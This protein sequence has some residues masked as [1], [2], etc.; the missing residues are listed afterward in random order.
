MSGLP[1]SEVVEK[2]K[3]I[4]G[5]LFDCQSDAETHSKICLAKE[6]MLELWKKSD[7]GWI[8]NYE[9]DAVK[10]IVANWQAFLEILQ[11]IK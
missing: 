5:T 3:A 6:Q 8:G 4:D 10:F 11:T 7:D 9:E 2:H 1:L